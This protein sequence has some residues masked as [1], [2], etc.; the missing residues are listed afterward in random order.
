VLV[1]IQSLILVEEP[2]FNEPGFE[3]TRN[4]PSG[5][6]SS[7]DYTANIRHQCIRWAM[8][9]QLRKPPGIFVFNVKLCLN[10]INFSS[11]YQGH[12]DSFLA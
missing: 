12:S 3:R 4:T 2:F 9:E 1:S 6:Q 7:R 5:D 11:V 8:I 10:K